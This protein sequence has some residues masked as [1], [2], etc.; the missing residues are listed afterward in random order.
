MEIAR[1]DLAGLDPAVRAYIEALETEIERLR[2]EEREIAQSMEDEPPLEPSEPPTT[3]NVI[4]VNSTGVAK[5][6][7]RHWYHR[8]RR[9][10]MGVFDLETTEDAPPTQLAI[11]DEGQDLVL[12]TN[13]AHVFHVPVRALP[14]SPV[15]DKGTSLAANLTLEPGERVALVLPAQDSAHLIVVGK[16]G[17][18]R[19]VSRHYLRDGAPLYDLTEFG[20]PVAAC[21]AP[22]EGDIL[23]AA[24]SGRAIRFDLQKIRANGSLGIQLEKGDA[25]IGV[26]AVQPDGGVFLLG[27]DGRGTIRLMSGFSANQSPGGMGKIAMKTDHLVGAVAVAQDDDIF[28]VSRLSKIIRFSASE[29]PPKEGV[30]QG[31]NC[32]TL[33]ADATAA[34]ALS[35]I[36]G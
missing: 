6:T 3:L 15:R 19:R 33:R 2:T 7:P 14:E 18:V 25:I 21:W 24:K 29:I 36:S 20:V 26:A 27:A 30:V 8:Q 4:T 5:R 32:M 9:G 13:M 34:V 10:G 17:N 23:I 28:I 22:R 1:P 31:V 12:I 11:A 16:T 35:P